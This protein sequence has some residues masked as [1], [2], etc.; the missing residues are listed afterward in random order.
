MALNSFGRKIKDNF[1]LTFKKDEEA[2]KLFLN[3]QVAPT[4]YLKK[5]ILE[6]MVK[7]NVDTIKEKYND[8]NN[9]LP[10]R[11]NDTKV[12]KLKNPNKE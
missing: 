2:I 11:K 10:K 4:A 7:S 3:E 8:D 1:S 5:L 12:G 6:D 9:N